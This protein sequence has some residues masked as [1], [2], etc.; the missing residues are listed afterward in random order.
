MSRWKYW[1]TWWTSARR[2]DPKSDLTGKLHGRLPGAVTGRAPRRLCESKSGLSPHTH[3]LLSFSCWVTARVPRRPQAEIL[4]QCRRAN[5]KMAELTGSIWGERIA[6]SAVGSPCSLADSNAPP[7]AGSDVDERGAAGVE[8]WREAC[9]RITGAYRRA[10]AGTLPGARRAL[11]DFGRLA[12]GVETAQ[13]FGV[14]SVHVSDM[15]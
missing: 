11:Q 10:L 7:A 9:R 2:G 15:G 4:L 1:E 5:A 6:S 12:T 3:G 13:M 14:W 8:P